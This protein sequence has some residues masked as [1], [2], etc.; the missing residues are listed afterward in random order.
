M[1][2]RHGGSP[3]VTKGN[4]KKMAVLWPSFLAFLA[5]VFVIAKCGKSQSKQSGVGVKHAR[6]CDAFGAPFWQV[7]L[8]NAR[9]RHNQRWIH[10]HIYI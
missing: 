5:Q 3:P 4:L 6:R 10:I 1:I 9:W 7:A 2:A 8:A